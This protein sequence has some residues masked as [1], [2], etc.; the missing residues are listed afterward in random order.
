MEAAAST[1]CGVRAADILDFKEPGVVAA[2]TLAL[3]GDSNP[4]TLG[5]GEF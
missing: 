2:T 4:P 5:A 3:A 1:R